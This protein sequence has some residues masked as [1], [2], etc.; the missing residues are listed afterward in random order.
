MQRGWWAAWPT[1][2]VGRQASCGRADVQQ[3]RG[4]QS[5]SQQQRAVRAQI[6]GENG[7]A[8][9]LRRGSAKT[10]EQIEQPG[11]LQ[12]EK[13]RAGGQ[14]GSGMEQT[15]V[16]ALGGLQLCRRVWKRRDERAGWRLSQQRLLGR[17]MLGGR[18]GMQAVVRGDGARHWLRGPGGPIA[19]GD[20]DD[21]AFAPSRTRRGI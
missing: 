11:V 17:P 4:G 3:Q 7:K 9:G 1:R 19:L 6:A 16:V 2:W 10:A 15:G 20:D 13:G 12:K 18:T 8:R 21:D 14:E 5:S